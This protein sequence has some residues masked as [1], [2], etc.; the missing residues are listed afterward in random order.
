MSGQVPRSPLCLQSPDRAA[1][2]HNVRMEIGE[3]GERKPLRGLR[4]LLC[5]CSGAGSCHFHRNW[6]SAALTVH[7]RPAG[8]Q[9]QAPLQP[10]AM[11]SGGEAAQ[12]LSRGARYKEL[13]RRY[14]KIALG[15]HLAVYA[16]FFAG[17]CGR[18]QLCPASLPAVLERS[19]N[20]CCPM[21]VH[22]AGCYVAVESKVDVQ[23]LLQKYGLLPG[24]AR[25]GA[26]TPP[27]LPN[28]G[29][30]SGLVPAP[31]AVADN[32]RC[33]LEAGS[34]QRAKSAEDRP[35]RAARPAVAEVPQASRSPGR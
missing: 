23:S 33:Q 22:P 30:H 34:S 9:T 29:C 35:S 10:A 12:Q 8:A 4:C 6:R 2:D 32:G 15:V 24:A 20:L 19:S 1:L 25:A 3:M 27:L 17:E 16:S 18:H 26:G 21:L 31:A 13:F 28:P 11:S 14:G 5:A 7:C